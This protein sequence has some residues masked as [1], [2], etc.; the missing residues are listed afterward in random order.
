MASPENERRRTYRMVLS[1]FDLTDRVAIVTG[2]GKGIG[3]GIALGLAQ[4]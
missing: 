3:R 2:A 1:K 4:A